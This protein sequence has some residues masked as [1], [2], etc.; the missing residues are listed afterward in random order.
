M[1]SEI[2]YLSHCMALE[3]PQSAR[4][5]AHAVGK[6][7][8]MLLREINPYDTGARLG[9]ETLLELMRVIGN[10]TPLRYMAQ[11]LDCSLQESTV[12]SKPKQKPSPR[13]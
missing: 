1:A 8:S 3:A 13:L 5:I 6:P 4:D 2:L 12:Q 9:V 11:E 10:L 7:Y